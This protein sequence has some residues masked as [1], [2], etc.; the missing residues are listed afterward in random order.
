M[1]KKKIVP[2]CNCG[3]G[4]EINPKY[5]YLRGHDQRHVGRLTNEILEGRAIE[6]AFREIK[7]FPLLQ[8]K[9]RRALDSRA[10]VAANKA[11]RAARHEES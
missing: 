8:G 4:G 3:C 1:N 5:S 11:E 6:S 9:V 10:R 2:T 7:D